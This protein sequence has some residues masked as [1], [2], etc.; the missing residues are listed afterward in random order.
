MPLMQQT[1]SGHCAEQHHQHQ[2][3]HQHNDV[4]Q[5]WSLFQAASS[6]GFVVGPLI[7]VLLSMSMS[8]TMV[9][10]LS[11]DDDGG[12]RVKLRLAAGLSVVQLATL[13]LMKQQQQQQQ[14]HSSI[15]INTISM[16]EESAMQGNSI[17]MLF[18]FVG[19]PNS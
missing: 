3:H 11:D 13:I 6:A 14:Q 18:P 8:M 17:C 15:S 12:G 19:Q 10:H 5:V 2:H 1:V 16:V 9:L 7:D 4:V